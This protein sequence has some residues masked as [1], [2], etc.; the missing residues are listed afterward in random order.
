MGWSYGSVCV[1]LQNV[2][3]PN[4]QVGSTYQTAIMYRAPKDLLQ[5]SRV[6]CNS[7]EVLKELLKHSLF[8][9]LTISLVQYLNLNGHYLRCPWSSNQAVLSVSPYS[10]YKC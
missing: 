10:T 4:V 7:I 9:S 2:D 5:V 8:Q 6:S 3:A 1:C